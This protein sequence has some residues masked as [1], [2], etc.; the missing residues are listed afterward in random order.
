MLL[1]LCHQRSK[2]CLVEDLQKLLNKVV[3]KSEMLGLTLNEKTETTIILR[4][5]TTQKLNIKI[6]GT[7]INQI[8]LN[9]WRPRYLKMDGVRKKC[10]SLL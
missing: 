9:I 7:T 1:T 3:N 6:G 8:N 10:R 2:G 4:Q 5:N